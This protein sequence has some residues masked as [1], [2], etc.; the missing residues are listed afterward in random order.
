M[1]VG[2]RQP[3]Q[4]AGALRLQLTKVDHYTLGDDERGVSPADIK[5]A[6]R[7]ACWVGGL[8]LLLTAFVRFF[9]REH[10]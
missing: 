4:S 1:I 7:M 5:R 2:E 6:E 10:A 9:R 8:A 3:P